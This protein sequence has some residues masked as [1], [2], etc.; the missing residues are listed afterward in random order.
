MT[1]FI[2]LLEEQLVAAHGRAPRRRP[3]LPPWRTTIVFAG[4]VAAVVAVVVAVLALASSPSPQPAASPP[5]TQPPQT[6]PVHPP[7][8]LRLAVLNGTTTTGVARAVADQLTSVG[9]DE[10]MLVTNDPTNPSRAR[11][12]IYYQGGRRTDALGVASC[13]H[14]AR[15]RVVQMD[16]AARQVAGSADVAVFVGADWGR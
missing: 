11:T 2:D 5:P 16:A 9:Y 6:T 8:P 3:A 4:A 10:P 7:P 1:D 13:L 14:V 12:T 15:D